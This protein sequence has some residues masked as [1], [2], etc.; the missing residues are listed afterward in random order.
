MTVPCGELF[1]LTISN[2]TKIVEIES[3]KG[4]MTRHTFSYEPNM[5]EKEKLFAMNPTEIADVD[6]TFAAL[7]DTTI[8]KGAIMPPPKI[9]PD[10]YAMVI[11]AI[12]NLEGAPL[13]NETCW[14]KGKKRS[15]ATQATTDK[16]GRVIVYL[17]KGDTYDVN[18]K[19]NAGYYS[20]DCSY[21]KGTSDIRLN[22]SYM[23]TPEVE[24]RK[25]MEAERIAAEEKRLK[26]EKERFEKRCAAIG[27]SL[28]DCL[29]KEKEEYLR[30]EIGMSDTVVSIV[31]ERNKWLDKLI[32]CDVT[33][34][35]NPYAA[36]L[37]IWYRLNY[38]REKNLQFV[39]FND[40]DGRPDESKKIGETGGIYYS[41]AKG[42]D[43]LDRFM[44]H[45]Q[46]LG[47]GG[48]APEN[49]MEALIK[50]VRMA[51]PF[52]EIVMIA[53]NNAPVK[54]LR[55]LASFHM[56]V[57]VIVCGADAGWI[58]PDYLKLAWRTKGTLHTI[59]E[60]I[61][62]LARLSEGQKI[63]IGTVTY[64]IMGGEFVQLS[65]L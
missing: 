1:D 21:S 59:E 60:D 33:G 32:I 23:G 44:S 53:D 10:Y 50:G 22:F 9:H 57:H 28:E 47:S 48:D 13:Q 18:F 39:L 2:Y 24:R 26:D 35:M 37:A 29:R 40:G 58:L 14:M 20:T 8:M 7:P 62:S 6:K 3:S 5:V 36:Q 16:N 52:K 54:D 27:L 38:A 15:K 55:L 45:V 4:G 30:G 41:K 43:S 64:K 25:R 42:V 61:T 34:S 31:I 17:P 65:G 11:I 63:T 12:R 19:Y 49:N 46:A 56:P 51:Q